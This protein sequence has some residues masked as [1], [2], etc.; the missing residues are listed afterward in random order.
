[1]AARFA[2]NLAALILG[3]LLMA[4]RFA[5]G[6]GA[7]R[8]LAFGL[9][10]AAVAS[11][12][13][14]FLARGRG[15]RQRL[16]DLCVFLTGGWMVVASLTYAP[17][18][19]GWIALGAGGAVAQLGLLGL[20]AHEVEAER[21]LGSFLAGHSSLQQAPVHPADERRP[22]VAVASWPS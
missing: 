9:S 18:V 2:S 19:V 8:W 11:V 15:A 16:L 3:A 17:A 5:F 7:A 14:A 22:P 4:D 13:A 6:P 12:G 1:M 10:C 21:A 20:V